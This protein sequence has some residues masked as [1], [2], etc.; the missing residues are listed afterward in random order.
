MT[1]EDKENKRTWIEV[2]E[3]ITLSYPQNQENSYF[4]LSFIDWDNK[5]Y[6]TDFDP[7]EFLNWVDNKTLKELKK[8]IVKELN[9]KTK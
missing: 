4:T 1:I 9:K 2:K 6:I 3:I 8:Y 7:Y 5:E